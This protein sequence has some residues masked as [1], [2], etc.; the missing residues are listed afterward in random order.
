MFR[1]ST[2]SSFLIISLLTLKS[3]LLLLT[4]KKVVLL[5]N[6]TTCTMPLFATCA[7][8]LDPENIIKGLLYINE[9]KLRCSALIFFVFASDG[10]PT[11]VDF[12]YESSNQ[13][14]CSFNTANCVIFDL[15][16]GKP[17]MRLDTEPDQGSN[18]INRQI[19]RVS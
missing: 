4:A 3:E 6:V 11:S 10:I 17:V 15:E 14:V 5:C 19:N 2:V 1:I 8:A 12:V 13:F 7:A 9:Q 16:T 18:S